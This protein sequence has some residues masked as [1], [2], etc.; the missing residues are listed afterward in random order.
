M[1]VLSKQLT[2]EGEELYMATVNVKKLN[3]I[4][5]EY[6]KT[7]EWM[8]HKASWEHITLGA[9]LNGYEDYIDELMQQEEK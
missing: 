2:K 5:D 8:Q 7:F 4:R 6:P 9:V 3:K 1:S